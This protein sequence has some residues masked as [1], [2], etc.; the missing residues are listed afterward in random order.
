MVPAGVKP[1]QSVL[2]SVHRIHS[3]PKPFYFFFGEIISSF[4]TE[5]STPDGR[6]LVVLPVL[7]GYVTGT[8]LP[9]MGSFRKVAGKAF[10][11]DREM[12]TKSKTLLRCWLEWN[13]N[14][15]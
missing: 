7:C 14:V 6:N 13:E 15:N 4:G 11:L 10:N 2:N 3:F 12:K 8:D 9:T 5:C 1:K